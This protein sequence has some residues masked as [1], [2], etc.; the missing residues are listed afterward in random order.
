MLI[1]GGSRRE[2]AFLTFPSCRGCP[3]LSLQREGREEE[4][5]GNIVVRGKHQLVASRM[6]PTRDL[7]CNPG[8]C[9]DWGSNWRPFGSLAGAQSTEPPQPGRAPLISFSPHLLL[10]SKATSAFLVICYS[11]TPLAPKFILL[12]SCCHRKLPQS[13]VA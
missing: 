5:E 12:L 7:A 4:R 9:P 1:Y 13:L 10:H 11:S 6:P 2:S 3:C 8:R